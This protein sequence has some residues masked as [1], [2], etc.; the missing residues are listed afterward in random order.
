MPV[1]A[2]PDGCDVVGEYVGGSFCFETPP[3][4]P[5]Q[6][7]PPPVAAN[8]GGAAT[9]AAAITDGTA[10]GAQAAASTTVGG[11]G[12]SGKG[13]TESP[14]ANGRPHPAYDKPGAD[15]GMVS[16]PSLSAVSMP[17]LDPVA[18]RGS[19][20]DSRR[21][22]LRAPGSPSGATPGSDD[23]P[24]SGPSSHWHEMSPRLDKSGTPLQLLQTRRV[25][26][27]DGG[28]GGGSGGGC[29]DGG[30]HHAS[31]SSAVH[32]PEGA[33]SP[34]TFPSP[35]PGGSSSD[36]LQ[37]SVVPG[38]GRMYGGGGGAGAGAG[39]ADSD[40]SVRSLGR[41]KVSVFGAGAAATSPQGDV[42]AVGGGGGGGAAAGGPRKKSVR[43]DLGLSAHRLQT[44]EAAVMALN[45]V[46]LFPLWRMGKE[47]VIRQFYTVFSAAL[48]TVSSCQG[49]TVSVVGDRLLALWR[50]DRTARACDAAL[51][52]QA[53]CAEGS[54]TDGLLASGAQSPSA[55]KMRGDHPARVRISLSGGR[56][57]WG[58]F[59][60]C[61]EE[62]RPCAV[63][64][65]FGQPIN[66]AAA[67]ERF[68][69][70]VDTFTAVDSWVYNRM[71][72][73]QPAFWTRP[74]AI[75]AYRFAP[76]V[77]KRP[78]PSAIHELLPSLSDA[79]HGWSLFAELSYEHDTSI[80]DYAPGAEGGKAHARAFAA[81]CAGEWAEAETL[82]KGAVVP[83]N[84]HVSRLLQTVLERKPP[85]E[86]EA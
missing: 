7:P 28:G 17:A 73:S 76:S 10:A 72:L 71:T 57:I 83:V 79:G 62:G 11:N 58:N 80:A 15:D 40:A 86:L 65:A 52:I 84:I 2:S 45:M 32:S 31:S 1:S 42:E 47:V 64:N 74:V 56:V 29:D 36:L 13:R 37:G 41:R 44:A 68:S 5:E 19:L 60:L 16:T 30:Q 82:L 78:Y 24:N 12:G 35:R 70:Q 33:S 38:A 18:R 55:V 8:G 20:A 67:V 53:A 69:R 81:A 54:R 61:Q 49:V 9:A 43:F 6:D 27:V 25:P 46:G 66:R 21:H 51:R 50:S 22:P 26:E 59:S 23:L 63:L 77:S 48:T 39:P 3:S 4:H 85:V 14:D 75:V 34:H